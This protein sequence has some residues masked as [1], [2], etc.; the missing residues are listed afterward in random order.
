MAAPE[1]KRPVYLVLALLGA[2][3]L[4][5]T[6]ATSGWEMVEL[7]RNPVD[8]SW[9][10]RG[11]SDEAD[12]A[13][14]V[15]RFD[16]YLQ[17]LD[18]ARPRGWPIGVAMLVLGSGVLLVSMRTLVGNR[19]ARPALVQLVVAQAA[20]NGASYWLMG[21]VLE[22]KLRFDEA[23]LAARAHEDVPQH[24]HAD[25]VLR[26]SNKM[27]HVVPRIE[28]AFGTFCS[29][30]VVFALTRRRAREHFDTHPEAL[31]EG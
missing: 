26:I 22:A 24:E 15:A 4:G 21:D 19:G 1:R 5:T 14:L 18:R 9:A 31:G 25:E 12:R 27:L 28:L 7:Y 23:T 10:G 8:P 11:V 13:A 3:A 17:A 16:G 20:L 29:A 6:G 2:L 30:L